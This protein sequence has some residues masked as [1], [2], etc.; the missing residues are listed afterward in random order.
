MILHEKI[1]NG[2]FCRLGPAPRTGYVTVMPKWAASGGHMLIQEQQF[3]FQPH[4]WQTLWFLTQLKQAT[5]IASNIFGSNISSWVD[6][7]IWELTNIIRRSSFPK[8][9]LS[10]N[11]KVLVPKLK[12][13]MG[14]AMSL[15]FTDASCEVEDW[16]PGLLPPGQ[17][18]HLTCFWKCGELR[19]LEIQ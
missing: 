18:P 6:H 4:V 17:V 3:L 12:P 7:K 13:F 15:W 1:R 5:L 9:C 11:L 14:N 2:R 8:K 19:H 16:G 10:N